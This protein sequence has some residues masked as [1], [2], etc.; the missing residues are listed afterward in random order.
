MTRCPVLK[1]FIVKGFLYRYSSKDQIDRYIGSLFRVDEPVS[2]ILFTL[3]STSHNSR[4]DMEAMMQCELKS[5][6][7]LLCLSP[8]QYDTHIN[9]SFSY[10]KHKDNFVFQIK[11]RI[12]ANVN[13]R[14]GAK[15]CA[16]RCYINQ[17]CKYLEI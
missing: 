5:M 17:K 7:K 11:Y 2:V 9:S 15:Q 14:S 16:L 3:I 1:E 8:L 12:F 4:S 6:H 10:K 13:C